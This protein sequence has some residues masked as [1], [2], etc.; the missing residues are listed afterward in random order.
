LSHKYALFIR[1]N[2]LNRKRGE[3]AGI[4]PEFPK[5]PESFIVCKVADGVLVGGNVRL[6]LEELQKPNTTKE[7]TDE[8]GNT[9]T[10]TIYDYYDINGRSSGQEAPVI[11]LEDVPHE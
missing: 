8:D 9:H 1:K 7:V 6:K 4:L 3:L 5:S 11:T 10:I 2:Q